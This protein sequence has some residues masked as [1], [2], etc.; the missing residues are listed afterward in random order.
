MFVCLLNWFLLF[1]I[2]KKQMDCFARKMSFRLFSD[3]SLLALLIFIIINI[4]SI[5]S[6][7]VVT[8][9]TTT[10]TPSAG[11]TVKGA[12]VKL[13]NAV[14]KVKN[15]ARATVVRTVANH[16]AKKAVKL[17]NKAQASRVGNRPRLRN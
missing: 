7:P 10:T 4:V 6:I 14:I 8:P 12:A 2:I 13:K 16:N 11:H 1:S 9:T 3:R 15:N 5:Q 17:A